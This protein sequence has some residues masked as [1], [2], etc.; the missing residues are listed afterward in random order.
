M[1][2]W[3]IYI[4][5]LVHPGIKILDSDVRLFE[6]VWLKCV[7]LFEVVWLKSVRLFEV[8]WLKSVRLFEVVWLKS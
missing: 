3:Q 5:I 6:V 8:V 7:R 4:N 1:A 2:V